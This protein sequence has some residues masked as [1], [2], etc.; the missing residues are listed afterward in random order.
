MPRYC[1]PEGDG[2]PD[3]RLCQQY[4]A[5]PAFR[6]AIDAVVHPKPLG[7][8][9]HMGMP[10]GKT[11]TCP[12]CTGHVELK[13]IE[14]AK[15]RHCTLGKKVE[16]VAC[17]VGCKDH[18][19]PPIP[20]ISA[21]MIDPPTVEYRR[22]E[23]SMKAHL[24]ELRKVVAAK[25]D[26]EMSRGIVYV[27]GGKF[28]PSIVV[29]IRMLR[30]LGCKL[31]IEVW[32]R[33]ECE[34]IVA[35]DV[36][37]LDVNLIDSDRMSQQG[38]DNRIKRGKAAVGGWENKL[39]ALTHTTLDQ[40][41]FLDADAYC[42]ADPIPLLDLLSP[43]EPFVF[44]SDLPGLEKNVKWE[45]VY[46]QG[47]DKQIPTVQGGQLLIDRRHAAKLLEICHW[48]NQHSDYYYAWMFG[49]Q[50][51][52]RVGLA[53][54]VCGY[55]HLGPAPW[56]N[57]AFVC[58]HE[59]TDYIVHRC[60]SKLFAVADINPRDTKAS[61]PDYSL[62]QENRV[63][64]LLSEVLR[65]RDSSKVFPAIYD[66]RLWGGTSGEGSGDKQAAP[67]IEQ[68][69]KLI[70]ERRWHSVVDAGC[71]DGAIGSAIVCG[72]YSGVDV[73]ADVVAANER[74]WPV[75]LWFARDI[76]RDLESLPSADVLLVKDVLHHWPNDM[77]SDWITRII[78]S[79]K[80]RAVLFTQDVGQRCD[81][82]DCHLGGYRALDVNKN[83]LK[84]FNLKVAFTY[85]H[86]AGLQWELSDDSRPG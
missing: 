4:A 31:P 15:H 29:G 22:S 80:W 49:D 21:T 62:P 11:K 75:C 54:G 1:H 38:C 6:A 42:V 40:V 85:L 25:S 53:A 63:F 70:K 59:G 79:R 24:E 64:C 27:G 35:A 72:Q 18:E 41:L 19:S 3:C 13:L 84:P 73:C 26:E 55:R 43:A 8:C 16:G 23:W 17:C 65:E 81:T 66:K 5:D 50:D 7:P 76:F 57:V 61:N 45:R 71:G 10:T 68:V 82:Q 56:R 37:G 60:Q 9:R 14:C 48:M 46:P 69:S 39:Y 2:N 78:A 47:A 83:P 51:T 12:T 77:V 52:W 28:W 34:P 58:G 33:G 86:K 20:A 67:Y 74:K 44:W 36:A 32:Y 30:E